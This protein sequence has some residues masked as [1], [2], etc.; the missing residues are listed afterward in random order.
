M[1]RYIIE[2]SGYK[3]ISF[4]VITSSTEYLNNLFRSV[5]NEC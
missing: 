5:S 3:L 2:E 4:T 1:D